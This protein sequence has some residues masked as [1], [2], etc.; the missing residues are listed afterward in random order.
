MLMVWTTVLLLK[1]ESATSTADLVK[2]F[3]PDVLVK[4]GDDGVNEIFQDETIHCVS[5]VLS[6]EIQVGFLLFLLFKSSI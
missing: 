6:A 1:Q 5:I 4:W 3:S 2:D